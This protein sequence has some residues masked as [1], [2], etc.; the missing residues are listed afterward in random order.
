MYYVYKRRHI[1]RKTRERVFAFVYEF[2]NN[3][4]IATYSHGFCPQ[5][6]H[7]IPSIMT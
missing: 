7:S 5:Y 6:S 2:L 1:D 3:V 4:V